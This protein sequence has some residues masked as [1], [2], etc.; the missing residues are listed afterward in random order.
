MTATNEKTA[1]QMPAIASDLGP[2]QTL[3]E[4]RERRE[5][6]DVIREDAEIHEDDKD[7]I[8]RPQLRLRALRCILLCHRFLPLRAIFATAQGRARRGERPFINWTYA[9]RA[10]H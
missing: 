2:A 5:A 10:T 4:E 9:K 1:A 6:H 3:D 8:L 7:K